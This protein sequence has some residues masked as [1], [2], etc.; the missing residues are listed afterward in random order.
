MNN[1]SENNAAFPA[2]QFP[3]NTPFRLHLKGVENDFEMLF[4]VYPSKYVVMENQGLHPSLLIAYFDEFKTKVQHS[5]LENAGFVVNEESVES[6][7]DYIE[8]GLHEGN[9]IQNEFFLLKKEY[10]FRDDIE[11]NGNEVE[12]DLFQWSLHDAY[13]DIDSS[14]ILDKYHQVRYEFTVLPESDTQTYREIDKA[15]IERY[16]PEKETSN[17]V[18]FG[19]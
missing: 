5:V 7:L 1:N 6:I 18:E 4:P 3:H 19:M 2:S 12:L 9:E 13:S 14:D 8:Y 15:V 10:Q 11:I 17:E 16:F